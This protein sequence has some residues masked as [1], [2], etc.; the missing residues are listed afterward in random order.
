MEIA[1]EIFL[2]LQFLVNA[3]SGKI[4]IAEQVMSRWAQLTAKFY[5]VLEES[6]L[7]CL[8]N[9]DWESWETIASIHMR[10]SKTKALI[11]P[12]ISKILMNKLGKVRRELYQG[13][14][15]KILNP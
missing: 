8:Q 9:N 7:F 3:A 5:S 13:D 2:K 6:L 12:F 15:I 10:I 11:N 14:F 1:T 4:T